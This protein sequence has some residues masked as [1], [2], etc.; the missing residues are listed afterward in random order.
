M[1][2][3]IISFE[4]KKNVAIK[5]FTELVRLRLFNCHRKN[6]NLSAN[7]MNDIVRAFASDI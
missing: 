1:M 6:F 3:K 2:H 4:R 7:E 5:A